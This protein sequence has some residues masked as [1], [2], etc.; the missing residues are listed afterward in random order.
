MNLRVPVQEMGEEIT[1]YNIR[2]TYF[3]SVACKVGYKARHSGRT[4]IKHFIQFRKANET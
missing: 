3:V 2:M 1:Y 4:S